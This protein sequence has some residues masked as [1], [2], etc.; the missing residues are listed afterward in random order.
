MTTQ[1][2]SVQRALGEIKIL[3]ARILRQAREGRYTTYLKGGKTV[4]GNKNVEDFSTEAKSQLQSA[5]DLIKR[6]RAI[7]GAIVQS[8]AITQINVAGMDLTVAEAIEM[9]DSIVLERTLLSHIKNDFVRTQNV[10]DSERTKAAMEL[11]RQIELILGKDAKQ[12][13]NLVEDVERLTKQFESKNKVE[14][15][16]PA[17]VE[18]FI[19]TEQKRIEDFLNDI[20]NL[21]LESNVKTSI[22]VEA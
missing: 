11:N 10:V 14:L 13:A 21:L 20:D 8:N 9:K 19:D 12:D 7:K 6:R 16:D 18:T 15:F 2:L 4:R 3:D 5:Q 17:K 1:T 22:T